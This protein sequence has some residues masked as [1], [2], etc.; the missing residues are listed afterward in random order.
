MSD[1]LINVRNLLLVVCP[2]YTIMG[3]DPNMVFI[4]LSP[5]FSHQLQITKLPQQSA[6]IIDT[7]VESY[8]LY[9]DYLEPFIQV[10]Q[11]LYEVQNGINSHCIAWRVE[12]KDEQ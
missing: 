11:E 7:Y 8:S 4:S 6:I 9:K 2:K 10:L 1:L 3:E 5:D 12:N